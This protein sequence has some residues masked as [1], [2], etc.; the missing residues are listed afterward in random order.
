MSNVRVLLYNAVHSKSGFRL[1]ASKYLFN[2]A[3]NLLR[4]Q[5]S[6]LTS[7]ADSLRQVE[8]MLEELQQQCEITFPPPVSRVNQ[9]S[10]SDYNIDAIRKQSKLIS[11][12]ELCH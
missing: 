4:G 3:E 9:T 7:C 11:D 1:E 6:G 8:Q 10:C 2:F 5:L 12:K